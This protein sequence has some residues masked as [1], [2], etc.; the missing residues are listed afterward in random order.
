MCS[1]CDCDI[2]GIYRSSSAK[3]AYKLA[4]SI[5]SHIS[6]SSFDSSNVPHK[7]VI[8]HREVTAGFTRRAEENEDIAVC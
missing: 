5:T 4:L 1:C 6:T 8:I 2:N 7:H 3:E